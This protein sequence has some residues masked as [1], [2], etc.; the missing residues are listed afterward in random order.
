M[1][2]ALFPVLSLN[3]YHAG[4]TG[5]G[6]LYASV[7]AGSTAT[8]LTTGWLLRA[9]YLGR[10]TLIAVAIWSVFIALAGLVDSI[11]IAAFLFAGAGDSVS[12][13]CRSTML[14]TLTPDRI[15]GRTNSVYGL[16]V[17]GGPR[18]GDIE[19]GAAAALASVPFAVV[20]G[21]L[22]CLASGAV[23]TARFPQL[24]AYDSDEIGTGAIGEKERELA[25]RPAA[26]RQQRDEKVRD[27]AR[28]LD[29]SCQPYAPTEPVGAPNQLA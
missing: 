24:I 2:R 10:I 4:A 28:P 17:A 15:R 1:P 26:L 22:A 5:T 23:V 6:L 11:W 19:S 20:S 18:L 16:V 12:A 13:V 14:Q 7:A 9:R 29:R 21:G 8:A 25:P 3:V 27:T